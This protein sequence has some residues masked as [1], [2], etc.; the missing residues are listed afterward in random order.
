[1]V[2]V[3]VSATKAEKVGNEKKKMCSMV[4][5]I[6]RIKLG[7]EFDVQRKISNSAAYACKQHIRQTSGA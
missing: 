5:R 2:I 3:E 4:L 7:V 1:M 6:C